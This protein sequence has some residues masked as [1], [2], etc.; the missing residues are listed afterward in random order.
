MNHVATVWKATVLTVH[1][2][3]KEFRDSLCSKGLFA[4]ATRLHVELTGSAFCTVDH[5]N[6]D[7]SRDAQNVHV[8]YSTM[9]RLRRHSRLKR[10]YDQGRAMKW[11]DVPRLE[12]LREIE[13]P[14]PLDVPRNVICMF[15][16]MD[17]ESQVYLLRLSA[18]A[19]EH[20]VRNT[21]I[22]YP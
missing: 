10:S 14:P 1:V 17:R 15:L 20:H 8:A 3:H 16:A 19:C 7:E 13:G 6:G 4:T 21:L 2:R 22:E 18:L 12:Q 5:Y 9:T 11:L